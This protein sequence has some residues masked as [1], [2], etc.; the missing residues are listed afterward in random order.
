[1]P[2]SG[3]SMVTRSKFKVTKAGN[4]GAIGK[5]LAK[6]TYNNAII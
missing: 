2:P 5:Y 6:G 3:S 1:M 4:D